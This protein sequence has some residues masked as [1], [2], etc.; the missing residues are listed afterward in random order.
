MKQWSCVLVLAS[1][2]V[3]LGCFTQ[4][5]PP[6][7]VDAAGSAT[8]GFVNKVWSVRTST[9]VSPGTIYVFL[10]DGTL[11]ITSPQSKPA[12]GSWTRQGGAFTMVEEGISYNVDIL[13]LSRD[14]FRIRSH[15]PGQPVEITM[16][17]AESPPLS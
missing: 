10:S 14:E 3:A 1:C 16:V 9:A 4:T 12:L 5:P 17:P 15:N 6:A 7:P 13:N 2:L 11:V 8:S